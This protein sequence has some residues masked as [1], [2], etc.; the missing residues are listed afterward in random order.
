M[1]DIALKLL[2]MNPYGFLS[3]IGDDGRPHTRLVEHL[4]VEDDA[5]VWIGTS[6][7]SRKVADVRRHPQ[8]TYA[9]E[10]RGA[11]AYAAI[12]AQAEVVDD[13]AE[14]RAKWSTGHIA[15]FPDGPGGGDFVLLRLRPSRIEL[16]DF[17]RQ[18]HPEPYG[19]Q[20]ALVELR[21][22]G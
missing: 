21:E 6:P 2:R 7:A 4:A 11:F 16:M 20:P 3:T 10:D 12:E 5:T 9:V 18:I 14:R 13:L 1:L 8:V 15:F 19:L 22:R 17:T